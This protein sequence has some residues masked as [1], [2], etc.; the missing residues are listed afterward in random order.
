[1]QKKPQTQLF[2]LGFSFMLAALGLMGLRLL[3]SYEATTV[4]TANNEQ[5]PEQKEAKGLIGNLYENRDLSH[6]RPKYSKQPIDF[7]QPERP[8]I[9]Q[10]LPKKITAPH[11][12]LANQLIKIDLFIDFNKP[13]TLNF[14]KEFEEIRHKYSNSSH[15]RIM[16]KVQDDV[17]SLILLVWE[18][19]M[20]DKLY[21]PLI[22]TTDLKFES[23]LDLLLEQ[24][25]SMTDIREKLRTSVTG[26]YKQIGIYQD[27]LNS[28]DIPHLDKQKPFII[29]VN[30]YQFHTK[31]LPLDSLEDRI[32]TLKMRGAL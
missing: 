13:E 3:F 17:N 31:R 22:N 16:P 30:G 24:G 4:N 20:L 12:G 29:L 9:A 7:A 1:M 5:Q 10:K 18:M 32:K 27:I 11:F 2:W 23:I 21:Q 28:L 14:L 19:G 6:I 25:A 15:L 8:L 26:Y